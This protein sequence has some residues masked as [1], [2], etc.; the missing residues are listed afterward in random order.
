MAATNVDFPLS[1]EPPLRRKDSTEGSEDFGDFEAFGDAD[2]SF[3]P[4]SDTMSSSEK[5]AATEQKVEEDFGEFDGADFGENKSGNSGNL[6]DG[7]NDIKEDFGDFEDFDDEKNS[8]P[9]K[10]NEGVPCDSNPNDATKYCADDDDFG[11][12]GGLVSD[13][14]PLGTKGKETNLPE[15]GNDHSFGDFGEAAESPVEPLSKPAEESTDPQINAAKSDDFGDFG[16]FVSDA[17]PDFG[18]AA[19]SPGEPLS[20]PTEENTDPQIDTAKSDDFGD[21]GEF[22]SDSQPFSASDKDV[23]PTQDAGDVTLSSGESA[24]EPAKGKSDQEKE[25]S[26]NFGGFA[27]DIQPADTQIVGADKGD[28]DD[29]FGDFGGVSSDGLPSQLDTEDGQLQINEVVDKGSREIGGF[30]SALQPTETDTENEGIQPVQTENG[31]AGFGE[32]FDSSIGT[33]AQ[34]STSHVEPKIDVLTNDDFGEF[35]AFS[36][37]MHT[38]TSVANKSGPDSQASD[39]FFGDFEQPSVPSIDPMLEFSATKGELSVNPVDN[40]MVELGG[41]V[42][43]NEVLS[44]ADPAPSSAPGEDQ[45]ADFWVFEGTVEPKGSASENTASQWVE[46]ANTLQPSALNS[47]SH[48]I[49]GPNADDDSF[50]DFGAANDPTPVTESTAEKVMPQTVDDSDEF[51]DF[52]E[53]VD[54]SPGDMNGVQEESDDFGDFENAA[55]DLQNG[56]AFEQASGDVATPQYP[57]APFANGGD[58]D[59]FGDFTSSTQPVAEQA[60]DVVGPF[61]AR[62]PDWTYMLKTELEFQSAQP[63]QSNLMVTPEENGIST[64]KPIGMNGFH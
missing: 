30:V 3:A 45:D 37:G 17:Q 20:Q 33:T 40:G 21:F 25:E 42:K 64:E 52:E 10:E 13:T 9:S 54:A 51:G 7:D 58:F 6:N 4:V 12:F 44:S 59:D 8:A 50:G 36:S 28:D 15:S 61:L 53:I 5:Q 56:G 26:C 14:Q 31:F 34:K 32:I 23:R 2:V 16:A 1:Q 49:P 18:E 39:A 43:D 60:I 29:A 62:V 63:S 19:E 27:S 24:L 46:V 38:E 55:N 22:V 48:D 41:S 11:D 57:A 47:D 35:G